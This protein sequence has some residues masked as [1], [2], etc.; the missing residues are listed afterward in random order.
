M[1]G[2]FILN[3]ST[4]SNSLSVDKSREFTRTYLSGARW[5]HT[6][7]VVEICDQLQ[8]NYPQLKNLPLIH[9]GYLHD[10]AKQKPLDRQKTLAEQFRGQLDPIERRIPGLW[11][12]PAGAQEVVT[13]LDIHKTSSLVRAIAYHPTGTSPLSTLLKGLMIADFSEPNRSHKQAETIR[14]R[15]GVSSLEQI[16]FSVI[17]EKIRFSLRKNN[18]LHPWSVE[19]YNELC[20]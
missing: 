19:V 5:D 2:N 8:Q 14:E 20:E 6:I 15:I 4:K 7:G 9:A 3:K 16:L 12:A 13:N 17:R 10:I 11:H 18:L 1:N